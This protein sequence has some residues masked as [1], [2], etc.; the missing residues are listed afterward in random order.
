MKYIKVKRHV[1][2]ML[3]VNKGGRVA[4]VADWLII[5]LILLNL[6]A[7]IFATV[8]DVFRQYRQIFYIFEVISVSIFTV[9]YGLRL[10]SA[11]AAAGYSR[12][13]VDRLRFAALPY[14]LIDLLAI[15]PFY[16]GTIMFVSDLRI[17]RALRL[18]RFLRLL[19]LVR[20]SEAMQRFGRV[21]SRKRDDLL[22]AITGSSILLIVASSLMYF[23]ERNAQPDVFSSIPATL[24]WGV[25]TLT[26]VGY[27]NMLPVTPIGKVLGAI[28]AVLG[29]GLFA[30][31]ASILA[32][33]FIEDD[34]RSGQCPHCGKVLD[35]MHEKEEKTKTDDHTKT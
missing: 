32:S 21:V 19:K 26:T 29:I 28:V 8:D 10:W 9:E 35:P 1:Y 12:P 17:L 13:V 27:G 22:L 7:V 25:V 4:R 33:G 30:L 11:T 34:A 14:L 20:Y 16:I 15:L 31:P 23:I 3:T 5:G 2:E 24:W 6:I 18:F